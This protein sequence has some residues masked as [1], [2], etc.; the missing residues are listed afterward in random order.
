MVPGI[1]QQEKLDE[2]KTLELFPDD[3]W[4][5]TYPKS[6]TVWVSHIARLI[7]NGGVRDSTELHIAV[8]SP[9]SLDEDQSI[10][11]LEKIPRP[12]I[13][14][15][16]FPYHL[17][18]CG[19]P[20]TTP[21]RYIY[22][23]RN[24]KDV[25]VSLFFYLKQGWH[26]DL[27]WG[28]FFEIYMKGEV[29]FGDYFDHLLSW[30]PH[31]DNKNVLF[32]TYE[33]HLKRD[34]SQSVSKIALFMGAVLPTES[35][36]KIVELTTFDAMRSDSSANVSWMKNLHDEN[37]QSTFLRKGIV[38]DWKNYLT[39]EQSNRID[40]KSTDKLKESGLKIDYQ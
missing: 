8:P 26:R 33:D 9:E 39:F 3:V 14:R 23:L 38:G 4:I 6:G 32:L 16:H 11:D 22:V 25:A 2:L 13:F 40:R 37:G 34:L 20:F 18:P 21:C 35:L 19:P 7:K 1:V 15:S 10:R 36:A 30:W 28:D 29:I 31:R 24:P 5:C 17:L 12:R 27:R